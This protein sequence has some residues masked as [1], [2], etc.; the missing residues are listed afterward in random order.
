[1][2][3]I[4]QL[5]KKIEKLINIEINKLDNIKDEISLLLYNNRKKI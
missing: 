5:K 3:T 2:N 4:H 1:M